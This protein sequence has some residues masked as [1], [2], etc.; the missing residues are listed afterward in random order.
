MREGV[1]GM[2]R[3]RTPS[4]V[5]AFI[6]AFMMVAGAA[7]APAW[8]LPFTPSRLAR[9]GKSPVRLPSKDGKI[10]GARQRV[11]HQRAREVL[12]G[13]GIEQRVLEQRLPDALHHAAMDLPQRLARIEQP[14][15]VV[16]DHVAVEPHLA[17]I[18]VDLDF[19]DMA[20]VGKGV[21][22][23]EMGRPVRQ[24]RRDVVAGRLIGGAR[25]LLEADLLPGRGDAQ[26][27]GFVANRIDAGLQQA[28]GK[29]PRILDD[30]FGRHQERGAALMHRARPAM[31]AAGIE[32][33][34]IAL[35]EAEALRR[36]AKRIGRDL[37]ERRLVALAVGMR[38]DH[39]IDPA[40][41]TDTHFR[42][43]IGLATRGF[44]KTGIAQATQP[45]PLARASPARIESRRRP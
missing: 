18:G 3:C 16:E 1:A 34:G 4:G 17:G 32:I 14:A 36:Q 30:A 38:A 23:A 21:A 27:A 24:T 33:V 43:F 28:R 20:A 31:A 2:S 12:A 41:V 40:V 13:V 29:P 19:G 22:V 6:T 39:Q 42:H 26:H 44:E 8:P 15:V 11:I 9:L 10:V 25:H 5:S 7:M 37:G 35:P 45:A